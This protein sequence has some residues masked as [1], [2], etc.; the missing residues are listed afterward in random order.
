MGDLLSAAEEVDRLEG[1]RLAV[2]QTLE[3]ACTE[4]ASASAFTFSLIFQASWMRLRE[5]SARRPLRTAAC[6]RGP[7]R[8]LTIAVDRLLAHHVV[9][10]EEPVAL[11]LLALRA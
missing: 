3:Q 9:D 2:V 1:Q 8:S 6:R 7:S 5:V 11:E 10:H 4:G